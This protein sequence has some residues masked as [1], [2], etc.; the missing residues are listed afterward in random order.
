MIYL[1]I[2]SNLAA[3]IIREH[4]AAHPNETLQSL[5]TKVGI[6]KSTL[7]SLIYEPRIPTLRILVPILRT[8]G[9]E[10]LV[11]DRKIPRCPCETCDH[12]GKDCSV[13]CFP[14]RDFVRALEKRRG[15]IARMKREKQGER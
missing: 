13:M 11:R 1:K 9:Y 15:Q 8:A 7:T 2:D 12:P 4:M 14:F 6:K 5:A 10:L 3:K